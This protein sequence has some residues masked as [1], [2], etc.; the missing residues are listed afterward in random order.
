MPYFPL[1]FL[2]SLLVC[3]LSVFTEGEGEGF[4]S[5]LF[6]VDSTKTV[7]LRFFIYVLELMLVVISFTVSAKA[8]ST[9]IFFS[10]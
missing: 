6:H 7:E 8:G 2:H 4:L 10:T 1:F 5:Q 9:R 3:F